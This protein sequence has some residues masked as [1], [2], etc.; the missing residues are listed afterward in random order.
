[1]VPDCPGINTRGQSR[2]A[3]GKIAVDQQ[4]S[5][6]PTLDRATRTRTWRRSP[7][8]L[9]PGVALDAAPDGLL[10]TDATATIV[11]AN[12]AQL[13]WFGHERIDL[14]GRPL[15]MLIPARGRYSR[16]PD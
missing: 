9:S 5:D 14:V 7:F 15:E 3:I 10:V 2:S 16:R 11:A 4:A 12:G 1:M 6:L 13:R 8:L